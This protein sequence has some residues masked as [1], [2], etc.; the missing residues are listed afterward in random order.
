MA[1][2]SREGRR[3]NRALVV[4][5]IK[6]TP[7]NVLAVTA[8]PSLPPQ[9]CSDLSARSS[10]SRVAPENPHPLTVC[11]RSATLLPWTA[12]LYGRLT[13]EEFNAVVGLTNETLKSHGGHSVLSLLLPLLLVDLCS[14]GLIA[15][16][17]PWLLVAPWD[18]ALGDVAL[19][20]SVEFILFF[21]MFPGTAPA[22]APS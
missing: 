12:Q 5:P 22:L 4:L 6:S 13:A 21:C 17:N 14:I 18:F 1:A 2:S 16:L 15:L 7:A 10:H 11:L 8:P 20:I 19:P 9:V 3:E